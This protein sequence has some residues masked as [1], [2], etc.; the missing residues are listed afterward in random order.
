MSHVSIDKLSAQ[1]LSVRLVLVFE[2]IRT[3]LCMAN[4][5]HTLQSQGI[6]KCLCG[7]TTTICVTSKTVPD[8]MGKSRMLD[9]AEA[10]NLRRVPISTPVLPRVASRRVASRRVASPCDC[11]SITFENRA[12]HFDPKNVRRTRKKAYHEIAPR[13]ISTCNLNYIGAWYTV[14]RVVHCIAYR[15]PEIMLSFKSCIQFE[16]ILTYISL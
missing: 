8:S 9:A 4:L 7:G 1:A 13:R 15:K 3:V 6:E 10:G 16:N 11:T 12:R 5:T 14:L 2:P